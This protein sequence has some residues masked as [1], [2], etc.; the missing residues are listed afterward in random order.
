MKMK[1][2]QVLIFLIFIFLILSINAAASTIKYDVTNTHDSY[3]NNVMGYV[4]LE[5]EPATFYNNNGD[6]SGLYYN[7]SEFLFE[8]LAG[9][10]SGDSVQLIF[11]HISAS[12]GIPVGN[13]TAHFVNSVTGIEWSAGSAG[14]WFNDVTGA[15]ADIES[16][17]MLPETIIISN[18]MLHFQPDGWGIG[19]YLT[20]TRSSVPVPEPATMFLLG[21]GIVGLAGLRK[22]I[23]LPKTRTKE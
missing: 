21:S 7:G 20:L 13:A 10:F 19:E 23:M 17:M 18:Y 16:Y 22:K 5:E 15:W 9:S 1:K 6:L 12:Q 4:L 2:L 11:N 3:G 8:S 14:V